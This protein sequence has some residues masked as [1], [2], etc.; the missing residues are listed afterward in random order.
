ML[1]THT[2]TQ[3]TKMIFTETPKE[4][5]TW[6]KLLLETVSAAKADMLIRVKEDSEVNNTFDFS[7]LEPYDPK[8]GEK[9]IRALVPLLLGPKGIPIKNTSGKLKLKTYKNCFTGKD[10]VQWLVSNGVKDKNTALVIGQKFIDFGYVKH[11]SDN[12]PVMKDEVTYYRFDAVSMDQEKRTRSVSGRVKSGR[13]VDM[14]GQTKNT[15]EKRYTFG[16]TQLSASTP[17]VKIGKNPRMALSPQR[18]DLTSNSQPT[19]VSQTEGQAVSCTVSTFT[20]VE[21]DDSQSCHDG[22]NS[23]T[24]I[25]D[26]STPPKENE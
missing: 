7:N 5:N 8:F 3:R 4:K 13:S 1:E 17:N 26:T 16:K 6:L 22:K 23:P 24:A 14:G 15:T 19:S 10:L 25:P 2:D 18:S 9:D 20:E 11:V 21:S 12:D